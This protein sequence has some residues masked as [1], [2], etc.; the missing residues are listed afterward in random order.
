MKWEGKE[1]INREN[2]LI[3]TKVIFQENEVEERSV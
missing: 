1:L 2:E 3:A